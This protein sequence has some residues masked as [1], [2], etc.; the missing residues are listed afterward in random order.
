V[1]DTSH[2][3]DWGPSPDELLKIARASGCVVELSR[4]LGD[5]TI[6]HEVKCPSHQAKV[7][8]LASLAEYDSKHPELIRLAEKL[9]ALG[10]GEPWKI[11]Q[12]VHAFVR[13]GVKHLPEPRE[14]FQPTM[15]TLAL[16]I[17]DCD[18]T[19]RAVMALL[20]A[21]GIKAGMLTLGDPPTHVAAGVQLGGAWHWL[22]ASLA[23]LPGEHPL[24]A[25]K[26]L[27]LKVRPDLAQLGAPG[28]DDNETPINIPN[29]ITLTGFALGVA[30]ARGGP[31]WM[32]LV[33]IAL[34]DLD[35]YAARKLNQQSEF[36]SL[37]DWTTD[38][39]LTP[40]VW[41][42]M[43]LPWRFYPPLAVAQIAARQM[44]IGP[45]LPIAGSI[46][47]GLMLADMGRRYFTRK[48]GRR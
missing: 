4:T 12:I 48:K 3:R 41:D 33:S 31:D 8:L 20:R 2:D 28:D 35:G 36:G 15:R 29:A 17:G 32:G 11:A 22:D 19:A 21:S 24:A 18:D 46:R 40:L 6:A 25:A 38:Q 34:D 23:A 1:I 16:G 9:S 7:K 5:G 47:A 13:D 44:G 10:D 37:L 26:R 42:R 39:L 45:V 43:K 14:K 30:W 27:G